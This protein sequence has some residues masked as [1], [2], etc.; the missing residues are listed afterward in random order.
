MGNGLHKIHYDDG[1][2][3]IADSS[4]HIVTYGY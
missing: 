1:Y 4:G 2:F 3:R